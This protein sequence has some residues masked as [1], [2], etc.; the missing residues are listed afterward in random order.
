MNTQE[1]V[2]ALREAKV[3]PVL[4][5]DSAEK[6][7]ATAQRLLADEVTVIEL[8]A[9]TP[10]W[11]QAL[12]RLRQDHPQSIFG[13]GTIV[14]A[15]DAET[16]LDAGAD[17]LVSPWPAEE[18]RAVAARRR[19]A[20]LEGGFTPAEVAA[21]AGRG[22]AKLFPAHVGGPTYLKSLLA[23]LPGAHVMPTGGIRAADV[24]TW[25]AA[26]ALAVGMGSDLDRLAEVRREL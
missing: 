15:T 20:F 7:Y 23:V 22:I 26:G 19:V 5:A 18:V 6:A 1:A 11:L 4:R 12:R 25:L 9:T 2:Q 3:V 8:T 16:A 13:V 24:A 14:K 21:A 17:F 10:D